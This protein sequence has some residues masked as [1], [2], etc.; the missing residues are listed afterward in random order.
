MSIFLII[1]LL[2]SSSFDLHLSILEV[3]LNHKRSHDFVVWLPLLL[4]SLVINGLQLFFQRFNLSN[5]SWPVHF[6]L[7][8]SV[9]W[10]HFQL[11][12]NSFLP[13]LN[14]NR[15]QELF[16]FFSW[17]FLWFILLIRK[18]VVLDWTFIILFLFNNHFLILI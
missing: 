1:L 4:S 11:W 6:E 12:H 5:I 9:F 7:L 2:T 13:L 17:V 14:W 16:D 3:L 8:R 10:D 18:L 15:W